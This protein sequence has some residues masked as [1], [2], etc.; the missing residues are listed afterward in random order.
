[1]FDEQAVKIAAG[2]PNCRTDIQLPSLST[3]ESLSDPKQILAEVLVQASEL[4][5]RHLKRFK[6]GHCRHLIT[7]NIEDFSPL[8][9]L[10]AFRR[11]NHDIEQLAMAI[12]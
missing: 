5:G 4:R 11:L 7:E 10:S 6:P 8:F 1:M 9:E 2:N 12:R 3:M